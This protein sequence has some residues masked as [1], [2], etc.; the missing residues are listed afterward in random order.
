MRRRT[1]SL[2]LPLFT[3]AALLVALPFAARA[4]EIT[5]T[6]RGT[7]TDPTGAVVPGATVILVDTGKKLEVRR[8]TTNKSGEYVAPLLPVGTYEIDVESPG[9][10][11]AAQKGVVV[12]VSDRLE[13]NIA[14]AVGD[15]GATVDVTGTE[16]QVQ[17]QNA[18]AESL[19]DGEQVRA[20]PTNNR[21]Y[22]QLVALQPGVSGNVPDQLYVGVYNYKNQTN[23]A[24]FS[25]GGG[26][27]T[28]NNWTIDGADNVDR[29]SN[30]TLL[31]YPSVDAI[32][33]FKLLR[34]TYNAEYG[35]GAAGQVEVITRSGGNK[36][37]GGVYEFLRND[38]M[39]ANSYFNKQGGIGKTPLRYNDFGGTFGGPLEIPHLFHPKGQATYFFFSEE[40]RRIKTPVQLNA[41]V[42]TTA[43]LSG[44]FPYAVCTGTSTT[45][46]NGATICP[47]TSTTITPTPAAAAYIKDVFSKVAA[48]NDPASSPFTLVSSPSAKYNYQEELYRVDHTFS[49]NLSVMG[50]FL[51]DKIPTIEPGGLFTGSNLPG[52]AETRT[53]SP[54]KSWMGRVTWA[55]TPKIYNEGGYAYSYGAIVSQPYGLDTEANSPDV[56][57]TLTLPFVST[58]KRIPDLDFADFENVT[59]FGPYLDFNR[60]HNVFDNL[61]VI[62]GNHSLKF[63]FSF[64]HYNKNE[65][66]AGNT[67]SPANGAFSFDESNTI[68]DAKGNCVGGNGDGNCNA[69]QDWANFL[70]GNASGFT[71][72]STDLTADIIE[73]TYEFYAQDEYRLRKNLTLSYGLRYSLFD[74]PTD[75]KG[76]LSNFAPSTFQLNN[77]PQLD[78]NGLLVAGTGTP[79]NGIILGG[80][81][82]P[83]GNGVENRTY[84]AF[85]PRLGVAYDPF[86]NGKDSIRAG[87]GIFQEAILAGLWEAAVY[88]NPPYNQ[89]SNFNATLLADPAAGSPAV[90]PNPPGLIGFAEKWH[91]S[92]IQQW[93]LD[94]Q[95]EL[96]PNLI[97]D[98][99]YY[100]QH[101]VHLVGQ[102][103]INEVAPGKAL[104]AGIKLPLA[105]SS[106]SLLNS[107]RPYPGYG[108][109]SIFTPAYGSNYNS[110][111]TQVTK[112]FVDGS[113]VTANYTWAHAMTDNQTAYGTQTFDTANPHKDY[114]PTQ[115]DRKHVFNADYVYKLPFFKNDKHLLGSLLG[116]WET[117]GIFAAE[118][119]LPLTVFQSSS[120]GDAAGLGI[121]DSSGLGSTA[122]PN[123]IASPNSGAPHTQARWFNVYAFQNNAVPGQD[124]TEP[125]GSVRGPGFW[126]FDTAVDKSFRIHEGVNFIFRA[127]AY[128][129]TNSTSYSAVQTSG[130]PHAANPATESGYGSSFGKVTATH[131]P[132]ILQVAGRITF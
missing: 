92:Y 129:V 4:Q 116:G 96:M 106:A 61:S 66:S 81:G 75:G 51:N 132:R 98:A 12:N 11:R 73:K 68:Y 120:N 103:D 109:I 6:I 80:K 46:A 82:S 110:L 9:F 36:F 94:I 105:S 65:N 45:D 86:G 118:T 57:G 30:R 71:Q 88:Q 74:P 112:R 97:L 101:G 42:P 18:S 76:I 8:V 115:L 100:G 69:Y 79:L 117:S 93:S 48:P 104:A 54:G 23:V 16:I 126:K 77:A 111:Q 121:Y 37:H 91:P 62:R 26:R 127:A 27:D 58:L 25:I 64:N 53:N 102:Q 95:H 43:M 124:G 28:Q 56:L 35:R 90:N 3:F 1:F 128:N 49:D 85:A 113:T 20:L 24:S 44:V 21:N 13:E 123:L 72:Q 31:N 108:A 32:E 78:S 122:R 107:L 84:T 55:I 60:N 83:Y 38:A 14:L 119:G 2:A 50:R 39:D 59:G 89:T 40:I 99:G 63:G 87:Y 67:A 47:N 7:I 130:F 10:K 131:D 33:E 5:G 125:R 70:L 52:V 41:N 29:G 22:E 114:G 17:L 34:G 19:I 15:S